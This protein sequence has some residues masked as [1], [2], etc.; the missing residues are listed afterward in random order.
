MPG[1]VI[2]VSAMFVAIMIFLA[3]RREKTFDCSEAGH[4]SFSAEQTASE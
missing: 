3:A 1:I 4:F 2:D